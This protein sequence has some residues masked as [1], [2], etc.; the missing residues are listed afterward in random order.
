MAALAQQVAD[1]E[2]RITRLDGQITQ[3]FG[4]H[5]LAKV[6]CSMPG[7]GSASARNYWS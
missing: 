7:S 3:R 6:I 1:L 5:R 2:V 4:R